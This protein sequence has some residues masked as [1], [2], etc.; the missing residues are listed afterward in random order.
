MWNEKEEGGGN[1]GTCQGTSISC[2]QTHKQVYHACGDKLIYSQPNHNLLIPTLNL[3]QTASSHL[4]TSLSLSLSLIWPGWNTASGCGCVYVCVQYFQGSRGCMTG[5]H[6]L[7]LCLF[8]CVI[9][10]KLP[11]FS[12]SNEEAFQ[13]FCSARI[14]QLFKTC[15]FGI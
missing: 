4:Q 1:A 3:F 7:T 2:T 15:S 11:F 9:H 12:P 13:Q 10:P 14:E 8:K 6:F 5:H